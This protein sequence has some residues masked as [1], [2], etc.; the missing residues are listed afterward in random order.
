MSYSKEQR[1][2]PA[3]LVLT[4]IHLDKLRA[5]WRLLRDMANGDAVLPPQSC[6]PIMAVVK[7][8]AY[9][10]GLIQVA[11]ALLQEGAR[12]FA[13]GSVA[14][15]VLLRQA[16]VANTGANPQSVR[17]VPLLGLQS[18]QEA[19]EIYAHRLTPF[20]HSKAQL[21]LLAAAHD[22][23]DPLPV[24]IKIDTGMSRLGFA[25]DDHA[26]VL[27]LLRSFPSLHPFLLA[28]HMAAADD[29]AKMD[30]TRRQIARFRAMFEALR[31]AWPD[32][33]P[34]FANSPATL[35]DT[36][37][38]SD[39]S[40]HVRRPGFALYGGNPFMG[41]PLAHL[42]DALQTAMEVTAPVLSVHDLAQGET[43]SY[44]CTFTAPKAMRVAVI[45][46]GYADGFSRGMSGKGFVCLH[47][48]RCP[49]LGRVCMQMHMVDASAVPEARA[50]DEAYLLGGEG[51]Q[52]ISAND[53]AQV[54]G[55]IPYEVFCLLGKNP[56][57]F[58]DN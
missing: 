23:A 43:V 5:N 57:E 47:G 19:L 16:L 8:D 42:G 46:A 33:A 35:L 10:H 30:S 52:S 6:T 48:V 13:V 49:I 4:R 45:G 20:V 17:V 54:W 38:T 50:G 9:G 32:L 31:A 36:E 3:G 28:T 37:L 14:E 21:E 55:T 39:F 12:T 29:P 22:G 58:Y 40:F 26:A 24:V 41:T 27:E 34:S 2:S 18:R 56:R 11:E 15:G 53:L 1:L 51:P 44:G 7:A 25:A